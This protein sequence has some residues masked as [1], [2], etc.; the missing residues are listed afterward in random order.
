MLSHGF[1][2]IAVKAFY[3]PI[4]GTCQVLSSASGS[5]VCLSLSCNCVFGTRVVFVCFND[6]LGP[7]SIFN[8]CSRLIS[9]RKVKTS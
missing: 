8:G 1:V 7:T 2:F 4:T 6:A 5:S 9:S 3:D